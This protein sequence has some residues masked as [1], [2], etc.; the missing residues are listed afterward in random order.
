MKPDSYFIAVTLP[1]IHSEKVQEYRD[2]VP[3]YSA[4][5]TPLHITL[6]PPFYLEL[7]EEELIELLEKNFKSLPSGE[8]VLN[9]V[10][11]FEHRSSVVYLKPDDKSEIYLKLLFT[12]IPLILKDTIK[13]QFNKSANPQ[14][15]HPHMTIAKRIPLHKLPPIK[16]LFE[17]FNDS[18]SFYAV[19]IDVYKQSHSY[20]SWLKIREIPLYPLTPE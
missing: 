20:G 3:L 8:I 17:D 14:D 1:F 16:K 10:A 11:Y 4:F 7:P 9:S 13:R 5:K 6:L 12:S 15:F 19:K 2:L 18:F